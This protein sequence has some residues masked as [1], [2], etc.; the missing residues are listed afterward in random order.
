MPEQTDDEAPFAFEKA[1]ASL[2]DIVNNIENGQLSL[3]ESLKQFE[4]G[5]NLT[6]QCQS[7]LSKAEQTVKQLIEK[8][9]QNQL[10]DFNHTETDDN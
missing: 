10:T 9:G 2:E 7:A 1:I 4:R 8:S 5:V 6:Q 3:E